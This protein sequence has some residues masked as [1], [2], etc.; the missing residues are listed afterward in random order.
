MGLFAS[1][2]HAV[3]VTTSTVASTLRGWRGAQQR[4]VA[5][6]PEQPLELFEY[7]GCPYCRLVREAFCE[8]QM[9]A[10]IYPTPRGGERFRSRAREVNGGKTTFPFLHDPNT[11][12][13]MPESKDIIEYVYRE[14][15]DTEP[16]TPG[17]LSTLT[18]SL[19]SAV[20]LGRGARAKPSRAP[21]Q[22][23]EL[24]SF[25][26]SPFSR[27]VRETLCELELPYRLHQVAK[28]Q[29]ADIGTPGFR[30]GGTKDWQPV[31]GGRREA[32]IERAGKAQVPYLVDPNTGRNMFESAEIVAY[33]NSEYGG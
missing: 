31:E 33:L 19:A 6:Q 21:D 22:P 11:G 29:T 5:R 13:A 8:I 25:E 27:L 26:A 2:V 9:D 3:S 7:E 12:K 14:Y 16:P 10:L 24:W 28:E 23:L 17:A 32:L 1:P 20:R 30:V 4:T 15:T 18:S